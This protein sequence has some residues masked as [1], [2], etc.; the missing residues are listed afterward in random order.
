MV[1]NE[2]FLPTVIIAEQSIL[3]ENSYRRFYK[4]T[5]KHYIVQTKEFLRGD[6]L[7]KLALTR[8]LIIDKC[9][10]TD[11]AATYLTSCKCTNNM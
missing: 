1:Q 8:N 10:Y 5:Q 6:I 9:T 2:L 4:Y 7:W 3:K 11:K